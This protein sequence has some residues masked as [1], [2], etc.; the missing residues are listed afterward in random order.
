[1]EIILGLILL[2][3]ALTKLINEL[4]KFVKQFKTSTS[5]KLLDNGNTL[6]REFRLGID[7]KK[8]VCAPNTNSNNETHE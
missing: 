2:A 3:H 7:T 4:T 6:K 1:M 5:R 8:E